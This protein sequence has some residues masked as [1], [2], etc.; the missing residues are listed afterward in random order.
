MPVGLKL[1]KLGKKVI[2]DS[3]EDVDKDILSKEWI[4][5]N[6]RSIVSFIYASYERYAC[7]KFDYIVTATPHIRD[8]FFK[9]K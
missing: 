2:F 3:H 6:L 5:K 7:K 9:N 1:K 4:P 8:K